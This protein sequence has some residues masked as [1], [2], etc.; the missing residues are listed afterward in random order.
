[1]FPRCHSFVFWGYLMHRRVHPSRLIHTPTCLCITHRKPYKQRCPDRLCS[2]PACP[3]I[4]RYGA[5]FSRIGFFC[6]LTNGISKL[7]CL[8]V[9]RCQTPCKKH[10]QK[11]FGGLPVIL[12]AL[13]QTWVSVQTR[14]LW[15]YHPPEPV[16]ETNGW[17]NFSISVWKKPCSGEAS[18]FFLLGVVSIKNWMGTESQRTPK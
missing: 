15:S 4:R 12:R 10:I 8:V 7:E 6:S 5:F 18:L 2:S 1:M 16:C 3:V 14:F 13:S 17:T 11:N 9:W